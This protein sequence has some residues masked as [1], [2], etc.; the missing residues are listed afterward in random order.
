MFE[1]I[2][3]LKNLII[4]IFI[5]KLLKEDLKHYE[6]MMELVFEKIYI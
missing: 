4:K 6:E 5:T 3:E 2:V 1:T